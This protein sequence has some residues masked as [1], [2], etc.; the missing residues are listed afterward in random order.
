MYWKSFN[1][2]PAAVSPEICRRLC[3]DGH[4]FVFLIIPLENLLT[5]RRLQ[6]GDTGG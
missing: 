6:Q 1:C 4:G 5:F 3:A 2:E